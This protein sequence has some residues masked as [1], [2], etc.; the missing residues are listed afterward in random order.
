M[1]VFGITALAWPAAALWLGSLELLGGRRPDLAR[2]RLRRWLPAH[3]RVAIAACVALVLI[4]VTG[5]FFDT[6]PAAT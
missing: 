4:A 1:A 3:Q 2:W 6:D 5:D